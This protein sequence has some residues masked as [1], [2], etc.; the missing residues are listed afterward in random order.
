M[1]PPLTYTDEDRARIVAALKAGSSLRQAVGF[2]GVQWSCFCKWLRAGRFALRVR[3]GD[4]TEEEAKAADERF[5]ELARAVDQAVAESDVALVGYIRRAAE[6]VKP[7]A[8]KAGQPE[9]KGVPGDWRAA[10]SL[11]KFRAEAPLRRVHL[12]KLRAEARVA[13]MRADGTLPA[14][15][16]DVTSDGKPIGAL[17]NE[18]L[19]ARLA[20]AEQRRRDRGG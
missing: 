12:R 18:E 17:T 16:H 1:A 20:A 6:G 11:L 7:Q 19:D 9:T 15:R 14:E 10:E 13:E 8:A 4:A 2:A 3:A 5:A